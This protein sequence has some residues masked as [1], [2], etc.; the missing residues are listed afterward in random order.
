VD[1]TR[2]ETHIAGPVQGLVQGEHNVVTLVFQGEERRTVPF[3]APP[4]PADPLIGRDELLSELRSQL[5]AGASLA[6][7]N[8]LPGVGKTT[9]AVALAHD[10]DVLGQFQDGV[11]WA[12]LG[13]QPDVLT[14]L[15][16]W[17]ASVG[18]PAEEM[19]QAIGV[20]ERAKAVHN[21]IGLRRMLLVVDDAWQVEAALA[22][23]VGGP[24]CAHLLTTRMAAVA[25]DF[26]D[27]RPMEVHE[28]SQVEGLQLLERLAPEVVQAEPEA[29]S[30][31]VQ[32]VGGLPLALTLLGRH[33]RKAAHSGQ[34]RR[35]RAALERLRHAEERLALEQ[36]QSPL[37]SHPSLPPG[38]SISLQAAITMSDAALDEASRST[39]RALAVFPPKPN[40]FSEEAGV[41]VSGAPVETL[42]QLTDYGMIEA[43]SVGRYTL[44]QTIADFAKV[45]GIDRTRYERM[46]S[47]FVGYLERHATDYARLDLELGNILAAWRAAF[48]H[49]M[50]RALVR[51]VNLG[52]PF[53]ETRGLQPLAQVHLR[54]AEQAARA[55]AD[56]VGLM[57]TLHHLG[58]IAA[59][60][61]DYAGA[62]LSFQEGL[63]L[64]RASGH[65]EGISDLLQGLGNTAERRGDYAQAEVRFQEAVTLARERSD[66]ERIS[67]LL[68]NLG[69]VAGNR[70][71]YAGAKTYFQEALLQ[72][73]DMGRAERT[74]AILEKLGEVAGS[75]GDYQQA[76]AYFQEGL[77][78]AR[79]LGHR[80]RICNLLKQLGTVAFRCGDYARAE[81]LYQDSLTLASEME[82][83]EDISFLRASMGALAFER[84]DY[85]KAETDLQEGLRLARELGYRWLIASISSWLGELYL[86]QQQVDAAAVA[87]HEVEAIAHQVGVQE[88]AATAAYGLARIAATLGDHV[89]AQRQGQR[90]LAI[91][92]AIGHAKGAEVQQWLARLPMLAPTLLN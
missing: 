55:V 45:Q 27:A 22:L 42:D 52:Y 74:S 32:A 25:L 49:G 91:F 82:S 24:N 65:R 75:G 11:L 23:K 21:A 84:G 17:G 13:R 7:L 43:A 51:G 63:T 35:L 69:A 76:A 10:P 16:T 81:T 12:G 2:Y 72:A 48:G 29:A 46:M 86:Q 30:T 77:V 28:L 79:E 83:R 14:L 9:L 31:L 38:A 68:Q 44:H 56:T 15:G 70:G 57:T 87:F 4:R 37:E 47:Y 6:L 61:G 33:L 54:R 50:I 26:A 53:M 88:H 67:V 58:R 5:M 62:E 92:E 3:L 89:D 8:G 41:E 19:A 20:E 59:H 60:V 1:A 39:L 90:S 40:T 64:A 80:K 78:L 71:D 73:R 85:A 34:P 66:R 36:P 18:V